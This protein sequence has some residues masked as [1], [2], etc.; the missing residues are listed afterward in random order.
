MISRD[1]NRDVEGR[2]K[3]Q[4]SA[5]EDRFRPLDGTTASTGL[6]ASLNHQSYTC[7]EPL[8]DTE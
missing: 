1:S 7:L 8:L 5:G 6:L 2:N 4:G 3:E